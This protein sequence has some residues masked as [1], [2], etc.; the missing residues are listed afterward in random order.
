MP[1]VTAWRLFDRIIDA[2]AALAALLL[3]A[4]MVATTVKVFYRYGLRQSLIG[5]DQISGTLLLYI[6][7]LGA[8]WVLRREGHVTIDLLLSHV[9]R[10]TRLLL[11]VGS[12]L[13]GA[14]VCLV[15]AVFGTVEVVNSIQRGIRIPA[16]IEIPRAVN[17]IVIP[18]GF[19]LLGL[20]FLRRALNGLKRGEMLLPPPASPV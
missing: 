8:A 16:E 11:M 12:S 18:I 6:A 17:L 2:L 13:I 19:L 7:F 1:V 3:I 10:R 5:V 15:V 20:Q 9:G 4:V 14:A